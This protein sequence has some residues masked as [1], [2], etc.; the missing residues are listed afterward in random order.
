MTEVMK[1]EAYESWKTAQGRKLERSAELKREVESLRE[2]L[3]E[4]KFAYTNAMEH[5]VKAELAGEKPKHS[6]A[7]IDKLSE[8]V[9]KAQ[10]AYDKI[11]T[12]ISVFNAQSTVGNLDKDA[13][14]FEWNK[15]ATEVKAKQLQPILDEMKV[16]KEAFLESV[17]EYNQFVREFSLYFNDFRNDVNPFRVSQHHIELQT[18][19]DIGNYM[20][21]QEDYDKLGGR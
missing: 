15:Y 4:A 17:K 1:C 13:M 9:N 18:R 2:K 3:T 11:V 16:K 6:D 14:T 8:I 12:K 20:V 5:A 7:D 21:T 10:L 19:A